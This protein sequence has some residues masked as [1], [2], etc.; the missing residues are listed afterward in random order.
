MTS[1]ALAIRHRPKEKPPA[2][3]PN[4]PPESHPAM[5]ATGDVM[6][7]WRPPPKVCA[8]RAD[9]QSVHDKSL[10]RHRLPS[11][12]RPILAARPGGAGLTVYMAPDVSQP[13]HRV[14]WPE[15]SG[16]V[17][18][19]MWP[20]YSIASWHSATCCKWQ[21]EIYWLFGMGFLTTH[22]RSVQ[23]G[24][25]ETLH[26]HSWGIRQLSMCHYNSSLGVA[27]ISRP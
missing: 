24:F 5:G 25:I 4:P 14:G 10:S 12:Q 19:L 11:R 8:G 26:S 2:C 1:T 9:P 27:E 18:A 13:A 21:D 17:D 6:P 3:G 23:G 15:H 7:C 20:T 16:D 22:T